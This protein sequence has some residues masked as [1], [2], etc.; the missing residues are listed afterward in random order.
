M[1][2]PDRNDA[3]ELQR[4]LG[5][6]GMTIAVAESLTGG[7]LAARIVAVPGASGVFRGGVVSYATDVKSSVLGVDAEALAVHGPVTSDVAAQM[8]AG[9][10]ALMHSDF[11]LATTG[12]AGPGQQG[13]LPP[14][15]AF[16]GSARRLAGG[17]VSTQSIHLKLSGDRETIRVGVVD[18]ALRWSLKLLGTNL[19][20][21]D[22]Q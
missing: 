9:V 19:G 2:V 14:G 3:P 16:V 20:H 12:V 15:Y 17:E 21:Q 7:L 11:A 5:D 1:P 6:L 8:A 4:R 18:E 10:L 22:V 13:G